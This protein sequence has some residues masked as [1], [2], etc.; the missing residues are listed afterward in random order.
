MVAGQKGKTLGQS[1]CADVRKNAE[2]LPPTHVTAVTKRSGTPVVL[3][4]VPGA[5]SS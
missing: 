2:L 1:F 4:Q 3:L 5:K